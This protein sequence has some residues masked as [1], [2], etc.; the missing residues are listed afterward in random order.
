MDDVLHCHVLN[1]PRGICRTVKFSTVIGLQVIDKKI[2]ETYIHSV[3]ALTTQ[4]TETMEN[5]KTCKILGG[6]ICVK[7]SKRAKATS[8]FLYILYL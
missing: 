5:K 7:I 6:P 4:I 3:H 1:F 8:C 2:I